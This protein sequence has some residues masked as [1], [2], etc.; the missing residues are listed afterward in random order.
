MITPEDVGIYGKIDVSDGE[1]LKNIKSYIK[2][3]EIYLQNAVDHKIDFEN[4]DEQV[5]L[6]LKE[7][8]TAVHDGTLNDPGPKFMLQ[9]LLIQIQTGGD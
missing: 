9:T 4:C 2:A 3:A 5:N 7:W 1:M 6:F 8:V